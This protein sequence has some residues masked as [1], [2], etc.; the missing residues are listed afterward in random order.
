M[1]TID[2]NCLLYKYETD[3]ANAI[4]TYFDDKFV[5]PE[6]FCAGYLSPNEEQTS[7]LWDSRA[8]KRKAAI[9]K[10]C[11][12][13]GRGMFFDYDTEKK[14][15]SDHESATAFWALWSGVATPE[16]AS[17]LVA[18]GLPKF[19]AFGGLV[20]TTLESRGELGPGR[21]QR[22][23]DYPYGWAPQ[24]ILAWAGLERYGF[25]EDAARL[26][27]KW[28]YMMTRAFVDFNGVVVEKYDVTKETGAHRVDAEY[29]NQ[30]LDF[31]GVAKE[32]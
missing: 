9:H 18:K 20:S 32:G 19:E 26:A 10:Y 1:A 25:G 16:Q 17:E 28:L 5:I 27:Y 24:Q 31:K 6:E 13:A 30:G 7:A 29:G 2:L 11:W 4:R 15:I 14:Q 8:E 3:I 22:Q 12:N 21:P 23:W